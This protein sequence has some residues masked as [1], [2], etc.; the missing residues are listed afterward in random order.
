ML[1]SSMAYYNPID[2]S[3]WAY[4]DIVNYTDFYIKTY[5]SKHNILYVKSPSVVYKDAILKI[6]DETTICPIISTMCRM[7]IKLK[8]WSTNILYRK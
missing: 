1:Y 3:E 8:Y 5:K 6:I 7:E 4:E 2:S